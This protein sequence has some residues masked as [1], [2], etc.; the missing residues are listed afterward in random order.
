MKKA[1]NKGA[2]L[3][4]ALSHIDARIIT[5]MLDQA[6]LDLLCSVPSVE[7]C[8]DPLVVKVYIVLFHLSTLLQ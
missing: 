8:F 7:N 1:P 2:F 3:F 5:I 4:V 6:F